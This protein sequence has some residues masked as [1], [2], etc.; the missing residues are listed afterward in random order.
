MVGPIVSTTSAQSLAGA[1]L[2][3]MFKSGDTIADLVQEDLASDFKHSYIRD[4]ATGVTRRSD[5]HAAERISRRAPP[6]RSGA[7]FG[8]TGFKNEATVKRRAELA[9]KLV[10]LSERQTK[11][12]K[13]DEKRIADG[14][15]RAAASMNPNAPAHALETEREMRA[16]ARQIHVRQLLDSSRKTKL[17]R[18]M[19][20]QHA[21]KAW[22]RVQNPVPD[23]PDVPICSYL[24]GESYS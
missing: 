23:A 17:K 20:S 8:L 14:T 6:G 12:A 19:D 16:A 15:Y 22:K 1:V 24:V 9:I 5:H 3:G 21:T 13:A 10:Q 2:G 4:Q 11:T 18:F 7:V